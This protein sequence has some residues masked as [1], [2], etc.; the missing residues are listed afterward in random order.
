MPRDERGIG[1]DVD[2]ELKPGFIE[3]KLVE[4]AGFEPAAFC[5]QSRHST[6]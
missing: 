4:V 6:S 5:L 1:A 3:R 2:V